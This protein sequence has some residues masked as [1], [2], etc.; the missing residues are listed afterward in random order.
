M[1]LR[2]GPRL[3]Q[4]NLVQSGPLDNETERPRTHRAFQNREIIDPDQNL[5][6]RIPGVK[7]WWRML[8]PVHVNR[9]TEE[10]RNLGQLVTPPP[11]LV[12]LRKDNDA[13][14][15]MVG[16]MSAKLVARRH[17]SILAAAFRANVPGLA[18]LRCTSC[19][20]AG[21]PAPLV[22]PDSGPATYGGVSAISA[23]FPWC[24]TLRG[25]AVESPGGRSGSAPPTRQGSRQFEHQLTRPI[26]AAPR[27]AR[28][29]R[30]DMPAARQKS[31]K[32]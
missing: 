15:R 9:D 29:S 8:T 27:F 2:I 11:P 18:D 3:L 12:P 16:C 32:R 4:L 5:V 1:R 22:I 10:L 19:G 17:F 24:Q 20:S 31:A 25:Q 28:L 7:M 13:A 6:A 30:R 14:S 23:R 26:S 21:S